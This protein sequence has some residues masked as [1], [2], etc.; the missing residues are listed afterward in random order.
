MAGVIER[1]GHLWNLGP[2]DES[3]LVTLGE[4]QTP[5]IRV[6]TPWADGD[7]PQ[8][9]GKL[10]G[11]N[12]TGSFKD[13]GMTLAVTMARQTGKTA[14]LCASTGNT[15]ASAAAYAARAGLQAVVVIPEGKVAP[16]KLLQV[17]AFGALL[18]EVEGAFDRALER[19]RRAIAERPQ[20]ELVNSV[21]P[22]RILGQESA[23]YEIAEQ[24][25]RVPDLFLLPVGN[26]GNITAYYRGFKRLGLTPPRFIGCQAE[27]A[28]SMVEDRDIDR[29]ETV[30]T[31]IRIG[32]PVS[33]A[34]AKEAVR[35]TQGRFVAVSDQAILQAQAELAHQGIFVEPASATPY[36]V[37]LHL[38]KIRDL[39]S[40]DTAVLVFTGNGLKDSDTAQRVFPTRKTTWDGS[41]AALDR[42]LTADEVRP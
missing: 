14:V 42:V 5:L 12:P 1:Y 19:L 11:S 39:P 31:A 34:F 36:A 16:G 10:E 24:L 41:T 32:K 28:A 3:K 20:W 22:W 4:G 29:P 7:G 21:N 13:R 15:A 38:W 23:A 8:V 17:R 33:R 2:L 6:R 26:A 27:G 25:G 30:A 18:F 37:L 40:A 9:F 35:S